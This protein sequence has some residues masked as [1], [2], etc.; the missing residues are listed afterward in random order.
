V[1]VPLGKVVRPRLDGSAALIRYADDAVIVFERET[2]ARRV[3]DVLPKRFGL[4]LHESKT[5]LV[6][7]QRPPR[8]SRPST[9]ERPGTFDF[10]GFTHYWAE[11]R[12]GNW[13]VKLK[14][15]KDRFRRALKRVATWCREHRHD[16]VREQH[17]TLAA[18]LKGHYAYFGLRGNYDALFR[19]TYKVLCRRSNAARC[20]WNWF[21]K[22]LERHPLPRPRIRG[23]KTRFFAESKVEAIASVNLVRRS[24]A[25]HSSRDSGRLTFSVDATREPKT[26]ATQRRRS[27]SGRAISAPE[28]STD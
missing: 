6:S 27:R 15:A 7:F 26:G 5:R 17:R 1:R 11:S 10:L 3:L 22:L 16:D 4:T 19:F 20:A 24:R 28:N 18:K 21:A 2:D 12:W 8:G 25:S 9:T 23:R 13:V 14:T